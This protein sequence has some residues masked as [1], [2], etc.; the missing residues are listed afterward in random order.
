LKPTPLFPDEVVED[1]PDALKLCASGEFL[2]YDQGCGSGFETTVSASVVDP[3]RLCSDPDLDP[4][5]LDH[6]DPDMAPDPNRI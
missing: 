5:S 1:H 2:A 3:N 4:G 6:S